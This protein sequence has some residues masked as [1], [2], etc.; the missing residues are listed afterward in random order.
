MKQ[1]R[2]LVTE[3]ADRSLF[4]FT[5]NQ[6]EIIANTLLS[7]I[8]SIE[9][10]GL[11]EGRTGV[12]LFFL[13]YYK[14]TGNRKYRDSAIAIIESVSIN[15]ELLREN[16]GFSNGLSGI[17]WYIEYMAKRGFIENDTNEIL[18]KV[19]LQLNGVDFCGISDL[20]LSKGLIGN[21]MHFLARLSN[22]NFLAQKELHLKEKNISFILVDLLTEHLY[23]IKEEGRKNVYEE[24]CIAE[25]ILFLC[26]LQKLQVYSEILDTVLRDYV[27]CCRKFSFYKKSTLY[28]AYALYQASKA[29]HDKELEE[30]SI[31]M[32]L[33]RIEDKDKA[34][35]ETGILI[36]EMWRA[37]LY[38]LFYQ[39]TAI[40]T[41][42]T[43][44][45]FWTNKILSVKI[46]QSE[47][48]IS[49]T[50]GLAGMGLVLI[51]IV[52]DFKP[53][54]DGCLLL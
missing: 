50:S 3:G 30:L 31:N 15:L 54:W 9:N 7:K 53:D 8:N 24:N 35:R 33:K 17:S 13:N 18:E 42:K 27:N 1:K 10:P 38:N 39:Q 46:I 34:N 19:C 22:P 43:A 51:S 12:S 23:G 52:A 47:M 11:L 36:G 5:Q 45:L 6:I 16:F 25:I 44:A 4:S 29:L 14:L 41:F 32:A 26:Q 37:H 28:T 40:E 49:I 2:I 48:D 21:G 20:S